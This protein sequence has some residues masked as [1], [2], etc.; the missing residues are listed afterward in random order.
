MRTGRARAR[1]LA[2]QVALVRGQ[3]VA[4]RGGDGDRR[5]AG[6]AR[7]RPTG[8]TAS[9]APAPTRSRAGRPRS[10]RTSSPSGCSAPADALTAGGAQMNFEFTDDQQAIKRTARDFLA[11]RYPLGDRAR[12]RRGRP[13]VHR[14]AVAAS[15]SSSGGPGVIVP[16]DH[17]G[18]G[19]G[20]G[21]AGGDRRGDGLRARAEPVVLD[22]VRG[23]AAGR[24]RHRGAARRGGSSRW[25]RGELRG[26]L[27]VWDEHAGWAPDHSEVE[28]SRRRTCP[29]RRSRCR[30]R[31]RPTS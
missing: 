7:R 9:C 25:P 19:L 28:P 29:R 13:R 21:R 2:R 11:A 15:W 14:R 6:D 4:D 8:P 18:L 1:G 23:A 16:E 12:A 10:S 24:G 5:A 30:T 26:T 27:A 3:P 22:H 17:G 20:R 31:R